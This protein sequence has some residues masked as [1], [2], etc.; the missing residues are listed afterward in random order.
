[1]ALRRVVHAEVIADLAD[2]DFPGVESHPDGEVE[3]VF[4]THLVRVARELL[5]KM[6]RRVARPLGVILVRDRRAEERHDAVAGELVDEALEALDAVGED[7]GGDAETGVERAVLNHD[8][9]VYAAEFNPTGSRIVTRALGNAAYLWDAESG[10]SIAMLPHDAPVKQ[11]KFNTDGQRLLTFSGKLAR[12]W[13]GMTGAHLADLRHEADVTSVD[14]TRDRI[15]TRASGAADRTVRIWTSDGNLIVVLKHDAAFEGMIFSPGGRRVVTRSGANAHLWNGE[16]GVK[17]AVLTHK[18][19]INSLHFRR[20]FMRIVTSASDDSAR[21]W[22]AEGGEQIA[23]LPHEGNV[24]GASYSREVKRSKLTLFARREVT[25]AFGLGVS[26]LENRLGLTAT[27][28]SRPLVFLFGLLPADDPRVVSTMK[29]IEA[30]LTV[31]TDIGGVARIS[32]AVVVAP[33]GS[34]EPKRRITL[35]NGQTATIE[36]A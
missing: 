22:D 35:E 25:P 14:F 28:R 9:A 27:I 24:N 33:P 31:K 26:R 16:S 11:L 7:R 3:G 5:L 29:A 17:I 32:G 23:L 8:G 18:A 36:E 13:D 30:R 1:M 10:A 20:D 4:E 19:K 2:D 21:L 34:E 15:I 6:E 12:L